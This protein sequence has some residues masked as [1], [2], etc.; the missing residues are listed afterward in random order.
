MTDTAELKRQ[1]ADIEEQVRDVADYLCS[2]GD[3]MP[4]RSQVEGQ[5]RRII[6]GLL[7]RQWV[8][9]RRA[10]LPPTLEQA[11]QVPEVKAMVD[12]LREG[13]DLIKGDAVGSEWKRKSNAFVR[14]SDTALRDLQGGE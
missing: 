6:H 3:T 4:L 10:D 13:R 8:V 11:L 1:V 5:A 9:V 7:Q 12:A 14:W 2:R